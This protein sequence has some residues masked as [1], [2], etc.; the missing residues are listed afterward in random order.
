[1]KLDKKELIAKAKCCID[2]FCM[3]MYFLWNEDKL[4][5]I[6]CISGKCLAVI[7]AVIVFL[8]VPAFLLLALQGLWTILYAIIINPIAAIRVVM[9]LGLIIALPVGGL[10][11]CYKHG[12]K[13][14]KDDSDIDC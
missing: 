9:T 13:A 4:N 1:M 6:D 11:L 10:M 3:F 8:V 5:G 12:K 2:D 14:N 7:L